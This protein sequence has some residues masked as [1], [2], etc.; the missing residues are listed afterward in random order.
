MIREDKR[1]RGRHPEAP[2]NEQ[3]EIFSHATIHNVF[4]RR[5]FA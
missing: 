2:F 4:R 1:C 3:Q 5:G